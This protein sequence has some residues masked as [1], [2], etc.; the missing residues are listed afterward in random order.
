MKIYL[1]AD[2]AFNFPSAPALYQP[3]D[4]HDAWDRSLKFFDTYLKGA[5]N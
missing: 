2:H 3:S 4:A 5:A 1:D